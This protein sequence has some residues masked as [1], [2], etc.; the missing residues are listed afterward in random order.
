MPSGK[1]LQKMRHDLQVSRQ[2]RKQDQRRLGEHDQDHQ[3]PGPTARPHLRANFDA[4]VLGRGIAEDLTD[5]KSR[6]ERDV[7]AKKSLPVKRRRRERL[8]EGIHAEI[9][10]ERRHD[11]KGNKNGL[12]RTAPASVSVLVREGSWCRHDNGVRPQVVMIA[13]R[14]RA[15]DENMAQEGQLL[16]PSRHS[17][18]RGTRLLPS[19]GTPGEGVGGSRLLPSPGTPGEGSGVR[20]RGIAAGRLSRPCT[21]SPHPRPLSRSTGRGGNSPAPLAAYSGYSGRSGIR[22]LPSPGYSASR[23]LGNG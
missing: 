10:P 7:A 23:R 2:D 13:A 22:L 17:G 11:G 3:H 8:A 12:R 14:R 4:D 21:K 18:R 9:G 19:P 16:Q 20:A 6:L 15:I 1:P 5:D